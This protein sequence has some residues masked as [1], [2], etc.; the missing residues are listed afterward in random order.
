VLEGESWER[1]ESLGKMEEDEEN[2]N[3]L[4]MS[5][6]RKARDYSRKSIG[7]P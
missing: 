7:L 1:W 6:E 4:N 5:K 2:N 3:V